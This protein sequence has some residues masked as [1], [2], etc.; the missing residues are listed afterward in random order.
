MFLDFCASNN[1]HERLRCSRR[2]EQ[3]FYFHSRV[4]RFFLYK[5][6]NRAKVFVCFQAMGE[7]IDKS[8]AK[9]GLIL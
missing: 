8:I 4:A 2:Q 3:H 1:M 7:G 5:R 9:L 6:L